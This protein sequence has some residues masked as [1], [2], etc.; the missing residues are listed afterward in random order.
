[1]APSLMSG[2][3]G[4]DTGVLKLDEMPK[5]DAVFCHV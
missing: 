4:E 5:S 1:M 3:V 2:C